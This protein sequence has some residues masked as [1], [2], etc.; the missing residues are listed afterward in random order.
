M[1]PRNKDRLKAIMAAAYREKAAPAVPDGWQ[2]A[3]MARIRALPSGVARPRTLD[4]FVSLSWRFAAAACALV[5]VL[6]AVALQG[7]SQADYEMARLFIGAP[8]DFSL[9]QSIG[10]F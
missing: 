1:T 9:V 5:L 3:A 7:G 10:I 6:S 4:E 2:E 8:L